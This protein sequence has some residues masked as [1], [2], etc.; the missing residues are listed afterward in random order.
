VDVVA[1]TTV[2]ERLCRLLVDG[3]LDAQV[4][5]E[6]TWRGP[7]PALEA[8]RERRVAGKVVLHVD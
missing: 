2:T 5:H 8:L 3:R 4:V 6:G 7:G 1:T